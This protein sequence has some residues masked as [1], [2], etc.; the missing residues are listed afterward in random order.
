MNIDVTGI[1]ALLCRDI[2]RRP[3]IN[4]WLSPQHQT[5]FFAYQNALDLAITLRRA[6]AQLES[7]EDDGK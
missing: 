7:A 2:A 5:I 1:E 3:Q 4:Q 6:I